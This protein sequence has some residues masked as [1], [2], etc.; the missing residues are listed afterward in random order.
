MTTL[1]SLGNARSAARNASTLLL[2]AGV[3]F[4]MA[5]G[6]CSKAAGSRA[7][8]QSIKGTCAW[9]GKKSTW[10]ARLT[11][12]SRGTYDAVYVSSWGGKPLHYVGT[13]KTDLKTH[14]S[15]RG[16]ASGGSANGSF[17]FSGKYGTDGI[18]KC[19][20]WEVGGRRNRKGTLTAE[21]PK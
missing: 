8:A 11:A 18:A 1:R 6:A 20:Y 9:G 17:E 16:K 2:A 3:A 21:L 14:I 15:G 10:S 19:K 13:I 12:R 4:S 5:L 7:S